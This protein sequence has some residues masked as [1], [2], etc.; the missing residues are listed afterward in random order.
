MYLLLDT[1]ATAEGHTGT[2]S[3]TSTSTQ[4]DVFAQGRGCFA[5]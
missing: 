1:G 3:S 5:G 4:G 2:Y